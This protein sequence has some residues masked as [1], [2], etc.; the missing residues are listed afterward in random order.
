MDARALVDAVV[1][2]GAGLVAVV[3]QDESS[4]VVRMLGWV[5]REALEKTAA[6]GEAHFWSRS[7]GALWRKGES[8]GNRLA[9][10]QIRLDC[11]GDAVLYLCEA[12]GPTC[13]TGKT[14]CFHRL[15]PSALSTGVASGNGLLLD[16]SPSVPG[17][18]LL[19]DG[20]PSVPGQSLLLDDGPPGP[21]SAVLSKLADVIAQRRRDRPTRSYV[22]SLLDAGWPEILGKIR[23]E[24]GELCEALPAGARAHT[25]HEAADLVFHLLVGL[26]AAGVPLADLL[27]ELARR[28]GTS[29]LDE[30]ASRKGPG[31]TE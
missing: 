25:A 31:A 21:S 16:R 28:F 11:D 14:S 1:W 24:A 4:G 30:K 8:S 5:N 26:E 29:G 10:R 20:T 7:R 19:L 15:P 13:H 2:N 18:S 22:V 6:T 3:V 9:V 27:A 17:Q 23:E 12:V